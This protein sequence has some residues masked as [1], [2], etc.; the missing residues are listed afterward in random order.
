MKKKFFSAVQ[1][2]YQKGKSA[3]EHLFRLTQDIYNG[4]KERKCTI[5]IFLDVQKAFDAVWLNGLKL[6]IKNLELPTQIQNIIFSFLTNRYLKVNVDG[7][8]SSQIQLKAGT[9]QGSC[10]SPILYLIFVNDMTNN[11][12]QSKTAA[13]QYADDVGLYSTHRNLETASNNVQVA[14]NSVM[15]WCKKWQVIMNAQKSQVILF[16]KCPSHKKEDIK[17]KMYTQ[18]IPT[19][20]QATYLGVVFDSKLSWET[21]ISKIASKSYGRLNLL[22]AIASLSLK[23]NPTLLAQL[24][25]S[26]IRSIFE[27]SSICIVS[28]ANTHIEKLQLI[29]N[30]ALRVILKVPAYMPIARMNDCGNQKNV[31]NHLIT[32]AKEKIGRLQSNSSL[33]AA[34][35]EKFRIIKKSKYNT[36]PLDIIQL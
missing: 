21:Q 36:S 26:T 35:I 4:F 31:K 7:V 2:G 29:Q 22:R 6:K 9:P 13:N 28:A 16:S 19:I 24:Y 17:L 14:L 5:G 27:H 25:N 15:S 10:L 11:V 3:E 18:V 1:A 33:V 32:V 23:P 8:D 20:T 34:T 12:D 30:E